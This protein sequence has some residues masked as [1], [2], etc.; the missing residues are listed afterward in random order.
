[1]ISSL[2]FI[3]S[4]QGFPNH[5]TSCCAFGTIGKLSMNKCAI[6]FWTYGAKVIEYWFYHWKFNEIKTKHLGQLGCMLL[7]L[8]QKAS[9]RSSKY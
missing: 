4:Y 7:I 9:M 6:S 5:G 3:L 1:M 2:F 8:F